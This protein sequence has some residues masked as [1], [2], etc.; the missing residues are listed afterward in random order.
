MQEG[1]LPTVHLVLPRVIENSKANMSCNKG[2]YRT[3][4]LFSLELLKTPRLT[5]HARRVFTDR[6][7]NISFYTYQMSNRTRRNGGIILLNFIRLDLWE[8]WPPRNLPSP[9]PEES[10]PNTIKNSPFNW[11]RFGDTSNAQNL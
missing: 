7:L 2:F 8:T 3:F 9:R 4:T 10:K 11:Y 6:S 1:F 5:C